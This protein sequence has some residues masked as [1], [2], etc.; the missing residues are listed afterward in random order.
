[1]AWTD[2]SFPSGSKLTSTKMTE[3]QSN[4]AALA[5]GEAGAPPL[6]V[7]SLMWSGVAS[8]AFLNVSSGFQTTEVGSFG[9]IP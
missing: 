8:G 6:A 4:F 3:V 9:Y 2:L 7:N 5:A 1:M